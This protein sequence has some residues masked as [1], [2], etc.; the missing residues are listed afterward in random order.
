M[1]CTQHLKII[2]KYYLLIYVVELNLKNNCAI[3]I[4]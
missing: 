1:S 2:L 4:K 3:K